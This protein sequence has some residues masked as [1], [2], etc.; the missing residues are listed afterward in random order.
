MAVAYRVNSVLLAMP[1]LLLWLIEITPV[2]G[3]ME[4]NWDQTVSPWSAK[5][6]VLEGHNS[7]RLMLH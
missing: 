6:C 5:L 2:V 3:L 7:Y 4:M 1:G